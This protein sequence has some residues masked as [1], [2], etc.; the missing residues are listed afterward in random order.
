VS[1]RVL[2]KLVD[3]VVSWME[4]NGYEVSDPEAFKKWKDSA[5]P[6]GEIYPELARLME[7]HKNELDKMYPWKKKALVP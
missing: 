5:P 6:Q 2:K 1:K 3:D 7:R 4:G